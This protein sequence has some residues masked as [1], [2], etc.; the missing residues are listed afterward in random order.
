MCLRVGYVYVN[1][2]AL[3]GQNIRTPR[4][5]VQLVLGARTRTRV[6]WKSRSGLFQ[7]YFF[8]FFNFMCMSAL[9]VCMSV[10]H[11]HVFC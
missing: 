2:S 7:K 4:E 9:S 1:G 10:H 3:R 11:L 6:F 8:L 5:K